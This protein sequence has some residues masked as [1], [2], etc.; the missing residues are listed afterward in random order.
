MIKKKYTYKD[1]KPFCTDRYN[2]D[3]WL[4]L[5][6]NI[7]KL[8]GVHYNVKSSKDDFLYISLQISNNLR[9]KAQ[10][11]T[12]VF[13]FNNL[14]SLSQEDFRIIILIN[15]C[16]NYCPEEIPLLMSYS[17]PEIIKEFIKW[18]VNICK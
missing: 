8:P 10:G 18:R 13:E 12:V 1:I 5:I 11:E 9:L 4:L 17:N 6:K 16:L 7:D 3:E 14:G 2:I 15:K